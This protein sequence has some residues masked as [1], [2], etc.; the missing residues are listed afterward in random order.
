[1]G[2][3][4]ATIFRLT[5]VVT[6]LA[7]L[8]VGAL[9]QSDGATAPGSTGPWKIPERDR[10]QDEDSGDPL[11]G[12]ARQLDSIRGVIH[13][14][15]ELGRL[16]IEDAADGSQYWIQLPDSVKIR[17]ADRKLFG[18][19]KQLKLEDLEIGQR[20]E[21]TLRKSTGEILKL[22]VRRPAPAPAPAGEP[23]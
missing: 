1:M 21:L 3:R 19:R 10:S 2:R 13:D 16:F 14:L 17:A 6:F 23:S 15:E 22:V 20:I 18:G 5:L 7:T 12:R 8:P 11:G 4:P 9:A